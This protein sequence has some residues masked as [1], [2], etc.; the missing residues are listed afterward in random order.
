[1]LVVGLFAGIG[2]LELG[3]T[4]S[5]HETS[6]LV[7]NNPVAA[8]VLRV[9]FPDVKLSDDVLQLST[10]PKGVDLVSAGFPCQD[11]SSV[12]PKVGIDG[13]KSS[14]VGAVFALLSVRRSQWVILENVPFLLHLAR[15][16]AIRLILCAL[17]ELGYSWCYR[18]I[19]AEAF[20]VPQRRRRWYL[21]ASLDCDP[22]HVLLADDIQ[23]PERRSA[24]NAAY[25]FYWTEGTRA[26][27]WAVDAVPPIKCGS[28]IGVASPPAILLPNGEVITPD[29]RDAERLQG[30]P[31]DWTLPAEEVDRASSRWRLVGNA[32]CSPVAQW[33]GERLLD[34]GQYDDTLDSELIQGSR[35]PA[36]AWGRGGKRY[37]STA[38]PFPVWRPR[39][40][41]VEFLDY[42]GKPL[43]ERATRGFLARAQKGSLRFQDGFLEQL[44]NHA[45]RQQR[46]SGLF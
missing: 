26:V 34:P 5:G 33:I 39:P 21:V 12:G 8:H 36:A 24:R 14:L 4:R 6:L 27:G 40:G 7:E 17:E 30:F 25:G 44:E 42:P 15:G 31:V 28:T 19:D 2:G 32:V 22:R 11:L 18:V 10:L 46:L 16:N 1:M 29:I 9:R 45:Q 38:G 43:S 3:L 37:V 20:G 35:W 23:A 13:S 41:L